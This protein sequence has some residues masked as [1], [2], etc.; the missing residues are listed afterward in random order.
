INLYDAKIYGNLFET[1]ADEAYT[2]QI[3]G[4][5]GE[6]NYYHDI[7]FYD[8]IIKGENGKFM[9]KETKNAKIY[10]NQFL[11]KEIY[12]WFKNRDLQIYDNTIQTKNGIVI[13]GHLGSSKGTR[14]ANN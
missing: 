4:T 3:E 12:I 10:N 7:A 2:L 8:N 13:Q 1:N 9:I 6:G 5:V 14:I 11:V